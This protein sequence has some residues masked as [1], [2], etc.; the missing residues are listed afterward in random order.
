MCLK[1]TPRHRSPF[2]SH[3]CSFCSWAAQGRFSCPCPAAVSFL[4]WTPAAR[5]LDQ[6]SSVRNR[7]LMSK[8]A[9]ASFVQLSTNSIP[10]QSITALNLATAGTLPAETSSRL[11][12]LHTGGTPTGAGTTKAF[13]EC[14]P[15]RGTQFIQCVRPEISYKGQLLASFNT[16]NTFFLPESFRLG[17]LTNIL[18]IS[19]YLL[20]IYWV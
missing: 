6:F 19:K 13:W 20:N 9:S 16:E 11:C 18:T 1:H 4:S 2:S 14:K 12:A 8:I 3:W 15:G 10:Q 7:Q 5:C 17:F